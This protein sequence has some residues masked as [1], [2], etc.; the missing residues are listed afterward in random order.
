LQKFVCHASPRS[1]QAGRYGLALPHEC[2]QCIFFLSRATP[3][4][5]RPHPDA[6]RVAILNQAAAT[7]I[8]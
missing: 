7:R 3:R 5:P 6:P 2:G 4:P 1:L 8:P